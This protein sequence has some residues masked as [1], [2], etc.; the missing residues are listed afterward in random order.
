MY[1]PPSNLF[2]LPSVDVEANCME[3][4]YTGDLSICG[5]WHLQGS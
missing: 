1:C 3:A 2:Y 4:I 5:F